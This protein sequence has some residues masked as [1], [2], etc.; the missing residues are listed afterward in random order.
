MISPRKLAP[1]TN[2]NKPPV[3]RRIKKSIFR[4]ESLQYYTPPFCSKIYKGSQ[5][6]CGDGDFF[7]SHREMLSVLWGEGKTKQPQP[8]AHKT[9]GNPV[10]SPTYLMGSIQISNN[11]GTTRFVRTRK[12][13]RSALCFCSINRHY[14]TTSHLP[15]PS[16]V[17]PAASQYTT[18][19]VIQSE[20][21]I[22][23]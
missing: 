21:I 18:H 8:V 14:Q 3:C 16:L 5:N 7:Y 9:F 23:K 15:S 20:N 6:K 10:S 11:C 1:E 22:V 2:V 4:T 12:R 19:S 17:I 13:C